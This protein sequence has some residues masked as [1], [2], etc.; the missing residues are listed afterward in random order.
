M[1]RL[2]TSAAGNARARAEEDLA[3]VQEALA[4]TEEGKRK[5]KV[6]TARLEVE[7]TSFLLELGAAKD[8][9]SSLHPQVGRDKE[10]M[11]EKYQKALEVI[12]T[13]GYGCCVFKHNICGDHPKVLDGMPNSADP[14]P[15]K[16][17]VNPGCPLV[18][19]IVEATATKA[20][21]SEMAKEPMEDLVTED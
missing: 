16:F 19:A 17:F 20:P 8:E 10:A 1:A 2:A 13:Y 15:P 12:F 4:A 14:L 18:Q 3:R 7:W 6:R 21:S 5:V 9:A 11:K